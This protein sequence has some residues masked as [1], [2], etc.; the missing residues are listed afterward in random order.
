MLNV[1]ATPIVI[2]PDMTEYRL[3]THESVVVDPETKSVA[4]PLSIINDEAD[5]ETGA[6]IPKLAGQVQLAVLF[7]NNPEES[8]SI[9]YLTDNNNSIFFKVTNAEDLLS[10]SIK[11]T[12]SDLANSDIGT[13][14][15]I[16][17]I[18]PN[19]VNSST[20]IKQDIDLAKMGNETISF[21]FQLSLEETG[22]RV[23]Y[24]IYSVSEPEE[25]Q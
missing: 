16:K 10:A 21:E 5:A 1:I 6:H 8:P 9:A 12:I 22:I 23:E 4:I 15:F 3:L 18:Q 20:R 17:N 24:W 7:N 14:K 13:D 2:A 11:E 25:N 19:L